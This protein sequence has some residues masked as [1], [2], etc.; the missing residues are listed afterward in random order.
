MTEPAE[1]NKYNQTLEGAVAF[2]EVHITTLQYQHTHG[3]GISHTQ[4]EVNDLTISLGGLELE[5]FIVWHVGMRLFMLEVSLHIWMQ[6]RDR[7]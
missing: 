6:P 1:G 3:W 2:E 7:P 4:P 5:L